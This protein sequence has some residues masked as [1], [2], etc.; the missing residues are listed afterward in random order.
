MIVQP[1]LARRDGQLLAI[2]IVDEERTS[3]D[4]IDRIDESD[5]HLKIDRY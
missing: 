4:M 1:E 3:S 2:T 5:N